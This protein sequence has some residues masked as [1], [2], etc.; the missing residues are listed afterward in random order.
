MADL[1]TQQM[2]QLMLGVARAQLAILDGIESIKPGFKATHAR[3]ILETTSRIRSNT[4]ETLS[5]FPARLLLQM[6]GR[7]PPALERVARDFEALVSGVG[8]TESTP[9]F[10]GGGGGAGESATGAGG[11]GDADSLDMTTP[12]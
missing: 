8:T 5:D 12:T 6:L 9:S 2:A 3:S 7:N 10:A 1:T 4:P 11:A